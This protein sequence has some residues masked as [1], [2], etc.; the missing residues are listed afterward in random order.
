MLLLFLLL[1]L[2]LLLLL[3]AFATTP[4]QL[5]EPGAAGSLSRLAGGARWRCP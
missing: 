5:G 3:G 2:L 4:A 1:L